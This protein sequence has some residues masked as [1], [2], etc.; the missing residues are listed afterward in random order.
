METT[1][2]T[3]REETLYTILRWGSFKLA[4]AYAANGVVDQSIPFDAVGAE[5]ATVRPPHAGVSPTILS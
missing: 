1:R 4:L 2:T 3:T 5:S